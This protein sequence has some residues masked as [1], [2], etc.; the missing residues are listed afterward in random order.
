[1]IIAFNLYCKI[2]FGQ[3]HIHN[4]KII[5][6][7]KVLHRTP[8]SVSWK[9]ANFSRFDETLQKRNIKGATHGSKLEKEI[10]D[11]FNSDRENFIYNSEK[12]ISNYT[13]KIFR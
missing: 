6:L 1:M 7:A 13:K 12:L 4:P 9:L 5:E 10:W 2:S 3:I 8:S 11:E